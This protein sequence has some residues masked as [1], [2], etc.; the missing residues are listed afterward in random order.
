VNEN[1]IGN[2]VLSSAMKV[3]TSLGPGLLESVYEL[4]LVHELSNGGL[5]AQRQVALPVPLWWS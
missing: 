3:H 5:K 4:C 2:E 1:A